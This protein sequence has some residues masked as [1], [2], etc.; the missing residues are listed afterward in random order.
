MS[1]TPSLLD[2]TLVM[3]LVSWS[4]MKAKFNR[5]IDDQ[6]QH[7]D[8]KFSLFL[9][10]LLYILQ[11]YLFCI[12][13]SVLIILLL[14]I[15]KMLILNQ[16]ASLANGTQIIPIE[17]LSRIMFNFYTSKSHIIFN[18]LVFGIIII[19]TYIST[20]FLMSEDKSPKVRKN[21]LVFLLD[22]VLAIYLVSYIVWIFST[23][24]IDKVKLS[25]LEYIAL[26]ALVSIPLC[27]LI[28]K[29]VKTKK[30]E[31]KQQP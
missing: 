12:L 30:Q 4:F 2:G 16:F 19:Y 25:R 29:L 9:I 5:N 23:I 13:L 28:I 1:E 20:I 18:L 14:Q 11:M 26:A 17:K 6:L 31:T 27:I 21:Q 7:V 8:N 22:I 10:V 15:F 3:F 24:I